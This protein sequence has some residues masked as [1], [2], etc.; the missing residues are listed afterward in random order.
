MDLR[1]AY[2]HT[3]EFANC[4]LW[5]FLKSLHAHLCLLVDC[6]VPNAHRCKIVQNLRNPTS[7]FPVKK[8]KKK[9]TPKD[10]LFDIKLVE[11]YKHPGQADGE[12]DVG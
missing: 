11:H 5:T 3:E 12:V 1:F 9:T 4:A 2:C 6:P 10:I 7:L 8:K